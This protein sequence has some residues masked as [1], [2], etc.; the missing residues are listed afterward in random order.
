MR[1]TS[2]RLRVVA[3]VLAM[4]TIVLVAVGILINLVLGGQ[5]RADLQ[6][7]LIDRAG[8]AQILAEQGLPAQSL[9][10]RL[11][12]DD[13]TV[14]Y[15]VG[16]DTVYGRADP[17]PGADR[18][19]G[20]PPHAESV[21]GAVVT[22][23]GDRL[24][25]TQTVAGGTLTLSSSEAG[26]D[27]TLAQLRTIEV[28][29][30]LLTIV[31][32]GLLLTG[33]VGVALRP[34]TRM[35]ALALAITQGGRGGRLRPSN[36]RTEIGRTAGAID[37]MLQALETA[38]NTSREAAADAQA[39]EATAREAAQVAAAAEERMRQLLADVSHEL[40]TPVAGLQASAETLLRDNPPRAERESLTVG[41]IQQTQRAARLVDDLLLMTRLDQGD[42]GTA[43]EPVDLSALMR[44]VL[45]EQRML[46][47]SREFTL[48][49]EPDV[50]VS[51]DAQRLAQIATNLLG[52]ARNA[53]ELGGSIRTDLAVVDG[54]A[55]LTVSDS[56]AGVPEA[57]RERIFE[58][59]VRL[60]PS[61]ASNRGGSGLGLSIA[62]ALARAHG[63]TLAC[64]GPIARPGAL[65]GARFALTLPLAS[66]E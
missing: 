50:W 41:M 49:I 55:Q 60:D 7:R 34:L 54:A 6:Q 18:G 3:A 13:V 48:T 22:Q 23:S 37:D 24:S 31:V 35:T 42:Q 12:G 53:T 51:G 38:E 8:Y 45:A 26:I 32:T 15:S 56:G 11:T 1:T 62:R 20:A 47:A 65:P 10:N 2:L 28:V 9:A 46:G 29:A 44:G 52:N 14:T 40:R 64:L 63:G 30:G 43:F 61:R 4:L 19:P 33:V 21:P 59:F 66:A 27:S 5:L 39:A 17:N 36:P 58:R 25:V 57:D 16:G